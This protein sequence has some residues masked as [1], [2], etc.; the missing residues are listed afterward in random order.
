MTITVRSLNTK[1][2]RDETSLVYN[3]YRYYDPTLAAFIS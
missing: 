1:E 3:R 2:D